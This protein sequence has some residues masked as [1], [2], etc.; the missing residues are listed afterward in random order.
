MKLK[1]IALFFILL[2]LFVI[3]SFTIDAQ[4]TF[5]RGVNL[6]GWFVGGNARSIPFSKF[7]KLDIQNIKSLGCDVIRLPIELHH[8]TNGAPDYVV[9]TLFYRYLDQVINWTESLQMNLIIDNHTIEVAT[10]K[11]VE[12]PLLKI[13]PQMAQ[14]YK[15][16]SNLIIYEILN[17]PNAML[18]SDWAAIQIKVVN[19][20]RAVDTKHTIMVSGA[21]WGG[22]Y[23]LT[24]LKKLADP[25]LI[26]SFHFY[27]PFLFTHQGAGWANPS[28]VDLKNVPFPYDAARMPACP[29][30]LKG[31]WVEGSLNTSYKTDGTVAKMKSTIDGVVNYA[32]ANGIKIYCGEFG[33]YNLNSADKDRVEWYK[34]VPAYLTQKKIPWTMWDYQ[35]GFGLFNKGSN[36]LFEYDINRP[37]ATGLGFTLPPMKQ[38]KLRADSIPFD[39]YTDTTGSGVLLGGGSGTGTA[40]PFATGANNGSYCIYL[41]ELAQYNNMDFDFRYNKDLS[42]LVAASYTLDFWM[43]AD[44]PGSSVVFRF[45]DTKTGDAADHPWR[46]DYT[47][48][49]SVVAFDGKWHHVQI[50]LKNFRDAGS[51][52]GSWFNA[53]NLFDWKA[54]DRF[55]IVAEN[56]ALTGKK[57]WFDNIRI[58]GNPITGTENTP[59]ATYKTARVYPNP[60]AGTIT[61]EYDLEH[62]AHVEISIYNLS[63]QRIST[64][65]NENQNFGKH[66]LVCDLE[67][68]GIS[69]LIQGV[70]LCKISTAGRNEV[71]KL[72]YQN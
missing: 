71:I 69:K 56:M 68:S 7:D 18:A 16:R 57:F 38:Y 63:G 22:I 44:S 2:F 65:L 5:N 30:S 11:A 60:F 67:N 14:H 6:T 58:T 45:L 37:L 24:N 59:S 10:T 19:A 46:R 17:E 54:V 53:A 34:V 29:A 31:T 48:N 3:N 42:K 23:G 64:V 55:Q 4:N 33:V 72:I 66:Q 61:I 21:D 26:Y 40:D 8:F 39:I 28:L 1:P 49:T 9:D 50:P 27:D 51:W 15:N 70:Y 36:E 20:I 25:N 13:W 62:A 41:T 52:D 43:K 35:G 32:T 12:A 47:I